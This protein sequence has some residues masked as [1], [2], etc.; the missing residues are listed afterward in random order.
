MT[1]VRD[2]EVTWPPPPV[3]V[4]AAP[5]AAA[6]RRRWPSRAKAPASP[7]RRLATIG[8]AAAVLLLLVAAA[9]DRAARA[10]HGVRAGDRDRLLRHRQR[11]PRAAHAADVGDQ[12]DLRDH[13]RR[14]AAADRPRRRRRSRSLSFV[15]ILLASINVFGGF[16]VTR[17]MLAMFS[18]ELTLHD[19][20]IRRARR[21][22]SSPPCCSSWR[23]PGC[24]STRPRKPATPTASPAWP[25]RW[26]PPSPWPST[27]TSTPLGLALLVVAM[28][29]G[30]AIGLWRARVVEMTGMP[31]LIALLH[32]FVGLAAVLVGWNG[33]LHVEGGADP[34]E[35][36]IAHRAGHCSASTRRGLHRRVHRR[37]HLHRLDRRVPQAVG[38]HQ[39]HAADA[40]RARTS[41]NVGA[42]VAFVALTVWFVIT[43][44]LWL[45]IVGHR[46]RAAAR[47]A[48]R[49][50]DRRRRHARRRVD[51]QQLLRLG[52][53]GV[54]LPARQRPADRHRRA[55]RL[56]RCL[57]VLH[58]VQGDEPVVHLRHRRRLRH[59]GRPRRRQGLRRAPRDQR[60]AAPPSCS[61]SAKSVIITPGYGMAVAQAQY[62]VA[63]L[64]PQAAR[65]RRRRSASASTPSPAACPAT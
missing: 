28:V 44:Q 9:P 64:H 20:R 53:G 65:A 38:P 27:A 49:R 60:R 15:A 1:V 12:R 33:Y 6:R 55:R 46:A 30:A 62:G 32:T 58:H 51:A 11:A 37:G 10:P 16:A 63:D 17:R 34:A 13:R 35:V 61:T 41:L 4:S 23:S 36:A 52:R 31:E 54:G 8:V 26:S 24:P 42:L 48:P 47:L 43:P 45:L 50:L 25:S 7:G 22:T 59:R 2:G 19:R 39:V 5:A 14:R 18:Q 3:Q 29:V 56:L 57:P 40:A 21:P